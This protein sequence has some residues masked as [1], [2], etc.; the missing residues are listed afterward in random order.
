[1]DPNQT[2]DGASAE[3]DSPPD[4]TPMEVLSESECWRLLRS[5]DLGRI[6]LATDDGIEIFPINF[7]VD[8]GTIVFRTAA[9][10]KLT[11][12]S[13]TSEIAFEAD[14]SDPPAGV[15]WSVVVKGDAE[16]IHGRTAVFDAFEINLRPWHNSNKPF[17]V[18]L[19]PRS[20]SGR[21]L[22]RPP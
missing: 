15:A 17:F 6:A 8:R 12:V 7:V 19:E 21:R 2:T 14:D 9:G 11:R 10:T 16:T 22:V 20:I 18:R 5:V 13:Q 3:D 4:E 1:M